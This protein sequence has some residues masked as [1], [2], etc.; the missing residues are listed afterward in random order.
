MT[1]T[2]ATHQHVVEFA[3]HQAQDEDGCA[4]RY[5]R[6]H[7]FVVAWSEVTGGGC[8]RHAAGRESFVV[9]PDAGVELTAGG[10]RCAAPAH[11][12][13][14]LPA[15]ESTIVAAT[16]GTVIRLIEAAPNDAFARAANRGSYEPPR[17]DLRPIGTPFRRVGPP[18]PRVYVLER[19]TGGTPQSFQTETMSCGWFEQEGPQDPAAVHPHAHG[20]FEEGSLM[21]AGSYVQHLRTPWGTDR[22]R[23]RPD[24]HL[25]CG[26]GTLVVIAP[27][28]LHVA[29]AVGAGRHVLMNVFAPPRPDHLA[30]GQILNAA[31]YVPG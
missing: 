18:A 3:A 21:V 15:G 4:T 7:H 20:D 28:T 12:I 14:I 29:E 17:S 9:L 8:L 13:A 23:W 30:K 22:H 27:Q 11:S 24:E 26:P 5:A 31:E 16:A 19:G 1:S 10:T 25:A 6:T 2:L